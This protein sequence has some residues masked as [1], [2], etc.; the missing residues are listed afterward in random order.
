MIE[1][2]DEKT[3]DRRA[4]RMTEVV[5]QIKRLV[6]PEVPREQVEKL[7]A[8]YKYCGAC[9]ALLDWRFMSNEPVWFVAKCACGWGIRHRYNPCCRACAS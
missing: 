8:A 9:Q 3:D 2:V 1:V 5:V 6:A 7:C 4:R